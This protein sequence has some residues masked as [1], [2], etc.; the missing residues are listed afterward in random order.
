MAVYYIDWNRGNDSNDGLSPTTAWK[1]LTQIATVAAGPGDQFLLANDSHW[2][3]DI[4][5]RVVFPGTWT[6]TENNPVIID[7]YKADQTKNSK[8]TITWSRELVDSD[9]TYSGTDNAW[10][11]TAPFTVGNYCMVRLGDT[12]NA[13]RIDGTQLPLA[14]IDGR[15]SNN[16]TSFYLYAPSTTNPT[17]YYG[18]VVLGITDTAFFTLSVGRGFAVI[19][20]LNFINCG[21]MCFLY[22]T[23][24]T[25]NGLIIEN[26]T[27]HTVSE[28]FR[29]TCDTG[30]AIN[31]TFIV[32]NNTITNWGSVAVH[33]FNSGSSTFKRVEIYN[34]SIHDGMHNYSQ[35]ALYIQSNCQIPGLIYNNVLSKARFGTLDKEADGC[36]IYCETSSNNMRVFNNTVYDCHVAL[37][38]NSGKT[39][40]WYGNLVY[41]CQTAMKISDDNGNGQMNCSVYN[42]T[43]IVG[44][45]IPAAFGSGD[46]GQGIRIFMEIS[47][48]LP[49]LYINNN[50]IVNTG[51]TFIAAI[52]TANETPVAFSY[53]NNLVF[54][55]THIARREY[56][57]SND[58]A[59]NCLTVDPQLT[60][61]YYPKSTS[62]VIGA[63][64]KVP[65]VVDA[66]NRAWKVTPSIGAYE[67]FLERSVR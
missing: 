59:N 52:R 62:L 43:F 18:K 2:V 25:A 8:P 46:T 16:G 12:W 29:A 24:T 13:S 26:C 21:A 54:N 51:S 22:N 44:K 64:K 6:G 34:N 4:A 37:Q 53:D 9:W 14:T 1:N 19:R 39:N 33:V 28:V 27:A 7:S 10:V 55:Y 32:R 23:G 60:S 58:T 47:G 65:V 15:Y 40:Y 17:K 50:I 66:L 57:G 63:G 49:S 31:N 56:L 45:S 42:N 67:Y 5:T 20:N 61:T 48:T 3:Y 11:Y 36:A 41:N 30:T 38:D 35:G